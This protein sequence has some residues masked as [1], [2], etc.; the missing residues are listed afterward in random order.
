MG[1]IVRRGLLL[2]PAGWV[3][4]VVLGV[5]GTFIEL[6]IRLRPLPVVAGRLGVRLNGPP[7]APLGASSSRMQ[8]RRRR[9]V[10]MLSRHW[11]VADREGLCLRRSLL[12]GWIYRD[13]DPLL[14]IGV[15]RSDGEITA[16]AWIELEGATL[17]ADG[18][19]V[20]LPDPVAGPVSAGRP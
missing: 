15:A 7:P 6:G 17:G 20:A 10:E 11:P 16:H 13:R 8:R 1:G 12:F 14:R 5:V 19:H 3:D 4:L 2:G 18:T 9:I